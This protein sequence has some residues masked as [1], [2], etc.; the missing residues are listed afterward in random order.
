[1]KK[2]E[3][4]CLHTNIEKQIKDKN[5]D[6]LAVMC[7]PFAQQKL[8][9]FAPKK[10]MVCTKKNDRFAQQKLVRTKCDFYATWP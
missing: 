7:L 5:F 6:L 4:K 2:K 8:D 10:R 9:G 3:V 1:L